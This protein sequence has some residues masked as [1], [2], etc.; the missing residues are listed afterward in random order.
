MIVPETIQI[1]FW[2]RLQKLFLKPKEFFEEVKH[3][4]GIFNALVV[5]LIFGTFSAVAGFLT[6]L[7][8]ASSFG[9]LFGFGYASYVLPIAGFILGI[10][11][12]FFY[13]ALIHAFVIAFNGKQNYSASYRVYA[14]SMVPALLIGIIPFAGWLGVIYSFVLMVIGTMKV[15]ELSLGKAILVCILPAIIIIMLLIGMLFSALFF[16]SKRMVY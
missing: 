6:S 3:E 14:Y 13:S 4:E 8:I 11:M 1:N 10:L 7:T 5:Y 15:H 9:F 2:D 12:T 16:I